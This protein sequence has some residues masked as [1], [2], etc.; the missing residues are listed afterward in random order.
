MRK[1]AW[2]AGF[3]ILAAG[4]LA[5]APCAP[6]ATTLCLNASRFKVEVDWRD[7]RGR[8]GTGQAVSITADTGYFWFFSEAN[9]ELV[10][11]VL[12]ARSIN[13]KFWV[14]FG[15]LS[16]VEYDLTVTDTTTGAVKAY[17]NPLGQFA[18][19]GDTSAFDPSTT[20]PSSEN[21]TADGT[22]IPPASL[23]SLQDLIDV[24]RAKATEAFTPCPDR[25][26][27]FNLNGCRFHLEVSW[28]DARGRT[29]DGQPVQLTNDTGYFWFFSPTN[30][31]LIVKVLDARSVNGNFWVFFGALTNV[32]YALTVTDIVTGTVKRYTNSAGQ[33]ASV[34]DTAAFRGGY[35]VSPVRDVA[36]TATAEL[37]QEG[38]SIVAHGADGSTFTLD[39]PPY[40]LDG[41]RTITMIPVSRIDR[42]PYSG[43]LIAGVELEP[44]GLRLGVPATLTIETAT[45]G[46]P[47][48]TVPYE[49]GRGGENLTNALRLLDTPAI[50]IPVFHFS[51][52]GAAHGS[53]ADNDHTG[54]G[55]LDPY[56][57]EYASHLFQ[58]ILGLITREQ[59]REYAIDIFV[60][61]FNEAI[62]PLLQRASESCDKSEIGFATETAFKFVRT[63][64]LYGLAEDIR[65]GWITPAVTELVIGVLESCGQKAFD[66]CVMRNDPFEA[67]LLLYIARQLQI[68][69]V[70]NDFLTSFAE[71]QAIETCLRF[72]LD[73]QGKVTEETT[74]RGV[75]YTQ[76][77]RYR[78]QHVPLRLNLSNPYARTSAWDGSCKLVKEIATFDYSGGDC[79]VTVDAQEGFFE[80]A[81][82]WIDGLIE[83]HPEVVVRLLYDPGDPG[84]HAEAECDDEGHVPDFPVTPL[85]DYWMTL[86]ENEFTIYRK[87]AAVRWELLRSGP[88]SSQNGAY[89]A[90]KSYERTVDRG[91]GTRLIEE[92]H[93]FLKH[94][95]GADR[96]ADCP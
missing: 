14:F 36:R 69:G 60:R 11:K 15:A 49:Y 50:A 26:F 67:T 57:S 71:G 48:E 42:L 4:R 90:K 68:L 8:T 58:E 3:L 63:M 5:A 46:P 86:H 32:E 81:A 16:S 13:Q 62:Q 56:I 53:P 76:R 35:S 54:P 7:S 83:E 55:P 28:R 39:F 74:S 40:S 9:I 70:E 18:S 30:V 92:T 80:A 95:P 89:F 94:T 93:F 34:G 27:G 24:Q 96:P 91:A 87:F 29:G 84:L 10:V 75:S 2:V 6:S 59:L 37:D 85:A 17:H 45:P 38:G 51:G 78:S 22:P 43:G 33:F 23:K 20:A 41:P 12:D 31:E 88:G 61:A 44:D 65:T 19:V 72:E 66:R 64:Q 82:L 25:V 77:L 47:N 73:F 79:E 1:A 52:Y 21:V